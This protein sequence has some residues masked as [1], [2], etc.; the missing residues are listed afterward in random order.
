MEVTGSSGGAAA[1]GPCARIPAEHM[2]FIR[3]VL[4]RVGDKWSLLL[5]AVVEAGPLRYTDLQRQVPGISQRMLTLTLRQLTEDGL[6]TRTAYAE[7]PPRVEYSLTPLG[8]GLH[9][10]VTSLIGWATDHHDEIR[11]HRARAAAPAA[12]S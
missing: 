7:V 9:E 2:E 1:V 11:R 10:I 4:D 3:Q 5:I 6:I 12:R 8:R